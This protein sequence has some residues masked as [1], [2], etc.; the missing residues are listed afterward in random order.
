MTKQANSLQGTGEHQDLGHEFSIQYHRFFICSVIYN[1]K[2][3][4]MRMYWSHSYDVFAFQ[5]L[6]Y[7]YVPQGR[8]VTRILGGQDLEKVDL[9]RH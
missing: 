7:W 3:H 2:Y 6:Q 9:F 8:S 1:E 4:F 5:E